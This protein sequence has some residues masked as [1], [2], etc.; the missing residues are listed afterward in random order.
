VNLSP[1]GLGAGNASSSA[2]PK[3]TRTYTYQLG[4]LMYFDI[5]YTDPGH[6]AT[7]FGFAGVDGSSLGQKNY[8]FSSPGNGIIEPNSVSFPFNEGCGTTPSRSTSVRVWITYAAG[9]HSNA[10]VIHLTCPA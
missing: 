1:F 8:S 4:S 5:Y 6:K 9:D 3:I 2:P 7:G 10:M